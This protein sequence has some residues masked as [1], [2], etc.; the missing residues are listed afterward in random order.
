MMTFTRMMTTQLHRIRRIHN[1]DKTLS[2]RL[3]DMHCIRRFK[4]NRKRKPE[5]Y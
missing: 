4:K 5:D 2:E 1:N 3:T